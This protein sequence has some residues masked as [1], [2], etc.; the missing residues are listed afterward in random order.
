MRIDVEMRDFDAWRG[1]LGDNSTA[2]DFF[3]EKSQKGAAADPQPE[4]PSRFTNH[5]ES[6]VAPLLNGSR[7]VDECP[8][9]RVVLLHVR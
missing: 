6:E 1:G 8:P 7:T 2:S 4:F 5:D 3:G 9:R